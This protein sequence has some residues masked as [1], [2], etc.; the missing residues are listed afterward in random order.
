MPI[1]EVVTELDLDV[2]CDSCGT[3]LKGKAYQKGNRNEVFVEPCQKC[4][5]EARRKKAETRK[6]RKNETQPAHQP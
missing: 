4:L 1:F 3:A 2:L 6:Q 5:E